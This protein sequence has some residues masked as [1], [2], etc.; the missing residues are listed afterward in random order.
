VSAARPKYAV[1][2]INRSGKRLILSRTYD[3]RAAAERFAAK[4]DCHP[5]AIHLGLRHE[6][7]A[8]RIDGRILV[9]VDAAR[10]EL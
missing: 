9:E 1:V 7:S 4:R 2:A 5:N 8:V 10:G 3:D 6:V